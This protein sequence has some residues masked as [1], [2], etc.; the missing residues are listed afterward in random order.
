MKSMIVLSL[1]LSAG[2]AALAQDTPITYGAADCKIARLLPA[3]ASAVQWNGKCKDGFADGVG[4]LTWKAADGGTMRLQGR[5]LRGAVA[6]EAKLRM[7]DKLT[8]IGSLR[9]G[10]PDGEGYLK[11]ADGLQYEGGLRMMVRE[12]KGTQ[13]YLTGDVYQ[14]QFSN[15]RPNGQGRLSFVLGGSIEGEF[16]DGKPSGKGKIVYAGSGRTEDLAALARK[17][18][19]PKAASGKT[20]KTREDEAQLGTHFRRVNGAGSLPSNVGWE[21]LTEDEKEQFRSQYPA[22]EEGDDPPYPEHGP[23]GIYKVVRAAGGRYGDNSELHLNVLV[24][25]DGTAKQVVKLGDFDA[26]ATRYVAAAAM[27]E[28]YKPAQCHGT[29]CEMMYPLHVR[30]QLV[31]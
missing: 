5:L 15:D 10:I 18:A 23:A 28:H 27:G 29:P 20:F 25:A 9:D 4:I 26:E 12:G 30:F 24:G 3:P 6:G 16:V 31:W 8:Y 22:L 21:M 11:F 17:E 7:G 19:H 2:S 14:G 1:A 13:I